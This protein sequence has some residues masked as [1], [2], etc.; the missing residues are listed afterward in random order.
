MAKP[1]SGC[2]PM[3]KIPNND[4]LLVPFFLRARLPAASQS[5][6]TVRVS[7]LFAFNCCQFHFSHLLLP[8]PQEL[9]KV[10]L[11]LQRTGKANT[12]YTGFWDCLY[13][14][15][16]AEGVRGFYRGVGATLLC[17]SSCWRFE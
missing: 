13:Q 8:G 6:R 16:K 9:V 3:Q 14:I 5:L 2:N 17:V 7:H 4:C 10:R 1:F 12:S 15:F 11:Q